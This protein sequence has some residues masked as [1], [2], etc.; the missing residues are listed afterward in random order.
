MQ[1]WRPVVSRSCFCQ[2]SA[3]EQKSPKPASRFPSLVT[4]TA[5]LISSLAGPLAPGGLPNRRISVTECAFSAHSVIAANSCA[6]S[7]T[8]EA[9]IECPHHEL[10]LTALGD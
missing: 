6:D 8:S 5:R 4:V 7:W 2:R 9:V 3:N 1:T 10:L